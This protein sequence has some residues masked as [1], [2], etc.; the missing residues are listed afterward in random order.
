MLKFTLLTNL[1][2]KYVSKN[3]VLIT[4]SKYFTI[5]NSLFIMGN[6]SISLPPINLQKGR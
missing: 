2:N 6:N 5:Y 1:S 3:I 4:E